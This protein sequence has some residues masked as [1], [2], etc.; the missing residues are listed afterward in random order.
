MKQRHVEEN[1]PTFRLQQHF[2]LTFLILLLFFLLLVYRTFDVLSSSCE[3]VYGYKD[4]GF[5]YIL[6]FFVHHHASSSLRKTK[7]IITLR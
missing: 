5:C 2:F 3:Y 1:I 4:A 6:M 7:A